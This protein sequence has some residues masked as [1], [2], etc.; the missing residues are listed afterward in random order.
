MLLK[1]L[2]PAT[3]ILP[4]DSKFSRPQLSVMIPT[5]NCAE[6][7]KVALNSVLTQLD[8][9]DEVQIEVIDD[10]STKDDPEIVVR[11]YGRGRVT[12]YGHAENKGATRNFNSC[13]QR[14]RGRWIHV[15][16]GDDFVLPGFY[17]AVTQAIEANPGVGIIATRNF[18]VDERGEINSL[19]RRTYDLEKVGR[20][21]LPYTLYNPFQFASVVISRD[22]V[23]EE[24]GFNESLVHVADWELWTRLMQRRGALSINKPLASYR[25]FDGNDTS[26]LKRTGE[27]LRD[28]ERLAALFAASIPGFD[29]EDFL[30]RN[31]GLAREQADFF[32]SQGDLLAAAS[33]EK[34]WMER[35]P[36]RKRLVKKSLNFVRDLKRK[37]KSITSRAANA[38]L[39]NS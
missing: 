34:F 29:S 37:A 12:F 18:V 20:N 1:V 5:Y 15:L 2:P 22:A 36:V 11:E 13:L 14:A 30:K 6:L 26:R 33:N 35:V 4:V 7:L 16:H 10:N 38:D 27:N 32:R 21:A 8:H 23:E 9:T 28:Y 31:V 24:G 19:S 3:Q 25:V 39:A 17:Q